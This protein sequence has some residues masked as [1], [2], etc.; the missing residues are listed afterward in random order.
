M[1]IS[2]R[3][4]LHYG[5]E[6]SRPMVGDFDTDLVLEFFQAF[7][8]N[9]RLNLHLDLIRG[10]NAHHQ[11]EAVFKAFALALRSAV[12]IDT[13]LGAVPSTK[14]SL[15]EDESRKPSEDTAG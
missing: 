9:A 12:R 6:V 2:G 14:G 4:Y 7:T 8:A 5:I 13:G 3:A 11:L 15:S 1:D 10:H